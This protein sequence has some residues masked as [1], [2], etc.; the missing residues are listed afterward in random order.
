LKSGWI[1]ALV[2]AAN[3]N[4][5][6]HS[7]CSTRSLISIIPQIWVIANVPNHDVN[8]VEAGWHPDGYNSGCYNLPCLGF[9][10]INNRVGLGAA[11]G[12]ISKYNGTIRI[13]LLCPGTR[14]AG[15]CG[16][17]SCVIGCPVEGAISPSK[18]ACVAKQL[19]N[20]GCCKISLD[21]RIGI[22]TPGARDH[23]KL[24]QSLKAYRNEGVEK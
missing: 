24:Q 20:M 10:Q 6:S 13:Y 18:V 11:F 22:D 23:S 5:K 19:H 4:D 9:V 14:G 1:E 8:T 2:I 15:A 7:S 12:P 21:D 17:C 3:H 16:F